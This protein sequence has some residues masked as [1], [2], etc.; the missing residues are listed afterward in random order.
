M[1]EPG[2]LGNRYPM[3]EYAAYILNPLW[4]QDHAIREANKT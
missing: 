2:P 4:H 1:D 3:G